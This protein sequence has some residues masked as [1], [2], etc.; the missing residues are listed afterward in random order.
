MGEWVLPAP[1]CVPRARERLS[2]EQ[3]RAFVG[4]GDAV[5]FEG[6]HREQVYRWMELTLRQQHYGELRRHGRGWCGDTFRR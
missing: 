3:I 5:V 2:P 6:R 4:A 1:Y